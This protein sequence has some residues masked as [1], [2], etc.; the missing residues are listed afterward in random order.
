MNPE[1]SPS[2][3]LARWLPILLASW[4]SRRHGR[5]RPSAA[6]A[7][8]E[9]AYAARALLRL[10]RGLTGERSLAGSAYMEDDA[11]LGAYLLYYWPVSYMQAA[12]LLEELRPFLPLASLRG[13]DLGCGPGPMAAAL[14]DFGAGELA[15]AD[16][17][18]PA[19]D[20]AEALLRSPRAPGDGVAPALSLQLCDLESGAEL[21][22]GPYDLIVFGHALN[23][24]WKGEPERQKRLHGLVE[25]ASSLLSPG[26][27]LLVVEPASLA[28]SREAL[29][30]RDSLAAAGHQI[31][32]PCPGSY[33]CPALAAGPARTCHLDTPWTPPESLASLAKAA[34]LDRQSVKCTWFAMRPLGASVEDSIEGSRV[35]SDPMLNKAGRVRYFLCGEAALTTISAHKDDGHARDL[36]FFDLRRGDVISLRRAEPRSGGLG[37]DDETRLVIHRRAP[38][39]GD[40]HATGSRARS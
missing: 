39:P 35:V 20:L 38:L 19:L 11:L 14:A 28:P 2:E 15:L 32:A 7:A 17:S 26:G 6:L 27:I 24:L 36:G 25:R 21:P 3:R 16:A 9:L 34:G 30:L 5:S 31:V 29:T 22:A 37:V 40:R 13:L 1:L 10:Q 23:E 4:R 8:D 18:R 12:L 33:A